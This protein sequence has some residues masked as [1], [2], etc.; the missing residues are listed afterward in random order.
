MGDGW[1]RNLPIHMGQRP[2][3]ESVV[4]SIARIFWIFRTQGCNLNLVPRT[5]AFCPIIRFTQLTSLSCFLISCLDVSLPCKM[6][7][8]NLP[9]WKIRQSEAC[10][11]LQETL[12]VEVS[13]RFSLPHSEAKLIAHIP[14]CPQSLFN[15]NQEGKISICESTTKWRCARSCEAVGSLKELDAVVKVF[16]GGGAGSL[17]FLNPSTPVAL[18]LC[19]TGGGGRGCSKGGHG[20]NYNESAL[21]QTWIWDDCNDDTRKTRYFLCKHTTMHSEEALGILLTLPLQTEW[22]K[23]MRIGFVN[24]ALWLLESW[25]GNIFIILVT[26]KDFKQDF[27]AP[28]SDELLMCSS[29]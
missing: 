26:K 2:V 17:F 8:R 27:W 14:V 21:S 11:S 7:K 3:S 1:G 10:G 9:E 29:L 15:L 12:I 22:E 4:M 25:V 19:C 28:S 23:K 5:H 20:E 24:C 13:T 16:L 6:E 18:V